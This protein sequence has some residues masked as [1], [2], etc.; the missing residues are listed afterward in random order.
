MVG[1]IHSIET[2]GTVDGPGMRLVIFFQGCP[3]RCAYCHNPDT[4][5]QNIGQTLTVEEIWQQY[6][7]NISFY[8]NGGIT[9][10]GGEAL[11]QLDFLIALFQFFRERNVH[12]CL[13]TSGICFSKQQE[14]FYRKLLTYTNLVILDIKEIDPERHFKL[15]GQ[16]NSN[17]LAF[18]RLI[19]ECKIPLWVRHVIVPTI[20]DNKAYWYELGF[21]LGQLNSL[22]AVDCLPY[23]IMGVH[24]YKELGITYPLE[25]IPPAT[26]ELA[27]LATHT[28]LEGIQAYRRHWWSPI[29][30]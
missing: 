28:I 11:L 26:K 18:A 20:T 14:S 8:K 3:M 16:D 1:H 30:K 6:E 10:S 21:F 29:K 24:K 12:T 17:I 22:Q 23:H 5:K 27:K 25:K 9:V 15:T 4:W 2:M 7:R 19:S 13:D